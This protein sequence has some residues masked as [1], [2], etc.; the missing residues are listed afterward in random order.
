MLAYMMRIHCTVTETAALRFK[1]ESDLNV[2]V[3]TPP[4]FN[5]NDRHQTWVKTYTV[6]L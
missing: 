3:Q 2:L 5:P 6:L 4:V 1:N